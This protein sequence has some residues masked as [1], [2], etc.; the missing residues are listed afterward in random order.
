MPTL[1]LNYKHPELRDDEV[2]I[3]NST[4]EKDD[5]YVSSYYK[6]KRLGKIAYSASNK[7]V[8]NL[9]PV[10]V[11]KD[12]YNANIRRIKEAYAFNPELANRFNE[13]E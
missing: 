4:M 11:S 12:E 9:Y 7:V 1:D 10:F 2:F 6:T 5:L 13:V 8:P 3:G